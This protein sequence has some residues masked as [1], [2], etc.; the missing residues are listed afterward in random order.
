MDADG[1]HEDEAAMTREQLD[2]DDSMQQ[3]KYLVDSYVQHLCMT[4]EVNCIN[5]E[6]FYNGGNE[7]VGD[8]TENDVDKKMIS[9][10]NAPRQKGTRKVHHS[11]LVHLII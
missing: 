7:I 2:H 5:K 9:K 11:Y 1:I 3:L 8:D 6:N 4:N 10:L